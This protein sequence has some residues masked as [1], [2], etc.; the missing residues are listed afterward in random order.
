[1]VSL[2]HTGCRL[3]SLAQASRAES[4]GKEYRDEQK[5]TPRNIDTQHEGMELQRGCP[6]N[7]GAEIA[8]RV[9]LFSITKKRILF[10]TSIS[11]VSATMVLPS[12][13]H[14]L[15]CWCSLS[16]VSSPTTHLFL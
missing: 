1:M 7:V 14:S 3:L 9:I 8:F 6:G 16:R 11:R 15:S 5:Y 10:S 4:I 12:T 2:P 13:S